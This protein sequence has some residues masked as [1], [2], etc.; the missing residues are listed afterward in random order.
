MGRSQ[1]CPNGGNCGCVNAID[2]AVRHRFNRHRCL[3]SRPV[4]P[5]DTQADCLQGWMAVDVFSHGPFKALLKATI[6][7]RAD[8]VT[9]LIGGKVVWD[10]DADQDL[11]QENLS[12]MHGSFCSGRRC[13][14]SRQ[15]RRT[16]G[17]VAMGIASPAAIRAAGHR[18]IT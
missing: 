12:V 13:L 10:V 4:S 1:R 3:G 11:V 6:P 15:W 2:A 5:R 17:A 14:V 16:D 9:C 8:D 7:Q 18:L